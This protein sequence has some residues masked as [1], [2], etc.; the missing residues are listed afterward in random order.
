MAKCPTN[1]FEFVA[2]SLISIWANIAVACNSILNVGRLKSL[3]VIVSENS[4]F[5]NEALFF[6]DPNNKKAIRD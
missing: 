1:T 4:C 6:S 3:A 2:L 5:L